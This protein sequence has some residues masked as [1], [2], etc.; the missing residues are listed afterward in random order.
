MRLLSK[1]MLAAFLAMFAPGLLVAQVYPTQ[2]PVYTPEAV[3]QPTTCTAACDVYFTVQNLNTVSIQ[4]TGTYTGLTTSVRGTNQAPSVSNASATWTTLNLTPLNGGATVTSLSANGTWTAAATALTRINVHVSAIATGSVTISMAGSTGGSVSYSAG[5]VVLTD[6][7]GTIAAG[8]APANTV[9]IGGTYHTSLPTLTNN[10]GASIQL[11]SSGR[12]IT[13]NA[14]TEGV[15]TAAT[16][17]TKMALHGGVYNS[18]APTLTNGQ[19]AALQVTSAGSLITDNSVTEGVITAAT[20]PTKMSLGGGVYNSTP[21][22][23]TNG[24]SAALQLDAQGGLIVNVASD[25]SAAPDPCLARGT[26]KSSVAVSINSAT[27]TQLVAISGTKAIYVCGFNVWVPTGNTITLEY[28]TGSSCGTGT[29]ALTGAV[30]ASSSVSMGYGGTV[31][32]APS[33]NALCALSTGTTSST[34]GVLTYVQ[35]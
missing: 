12:L 35:Q 7:E 6:V 24:Q 34:A 19:S 18:A 22:T 25:T 21:P 17:P 31:M 5:S 16:A 13:D 26:A 8:T 20:A 14:G 11:D 27:T 1:V 29:T 3:V 4:L 33:A 23:L 28:G 9:V 2:T 15:I 30:P 10:Q 32:T